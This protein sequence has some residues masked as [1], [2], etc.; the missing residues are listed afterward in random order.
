MKHAMAFVAGSRRAAQRAVGLICFAAMTA[1]GGGGGGGVEAPPVTII[2]ESL[3]ISG[4][5]GADASTAVQ[6]SNSTSALSG[7]K[8]SWDFGDGTSSSEAVPSHTYAHGGDFTVVLKVTNESGAS[9]EVRSRVSVTNLATV[10]GLAC[11]GASDT[12][13]CWQQPRPTGTDHLDTFFIS[14]SL[15]FRVGYRA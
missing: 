6:F 15:E 8:F 14:G 9:K 11:T 4:P 5:S 10:R 3:A 2:P 13:W 12:G 7:L 1:C